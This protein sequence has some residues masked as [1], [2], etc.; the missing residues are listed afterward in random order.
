MMNAADSNPPT[1][2]AQMVA[3]CTCRGSRSQPKSHSPRNTDSRKNAAR[4]SM[5]RGA[6]KT[7]PTNRE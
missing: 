4:P 6:P 5:A 7:S 1:A 2:T 3:R